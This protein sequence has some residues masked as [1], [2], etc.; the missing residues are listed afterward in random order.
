MT[1][2]QPHSLNSLVLSLADEVLQSIANRENGE[3]NDFADK[4]RT[5]RP[6]S[7]SATPRGTATPRL[8]LG[9]GNTLRFSM[10]G[11]GAAES[12][13]PRR[14]VSSIPY[15]P[16][17][18][19]RVWSYSAKVNQWVRACP[20]LMARYTLGPC[21][22]HATP[23][24]RRDLFDE[25][26]CY[27]VGSHYGIQWNE[28]ATGLHPNVRTLKFSDV[29]IVETPGGSL[30]AAY[31]IR[32]AMPMATGGM[33]REGKSSFAHRAVTLSNTIHAFLHFTYLRSRGRFVVALQ[34]VDPLTYVVSR[35]CIFPK[36]EGD[37]FA[38]REGT[39]GPKRCKE[40]VEQHICDVSCQA[41]RLEPILYL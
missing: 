3:K 41:L 24:Q 15:S 34:S 37:V 2:P 40:L 5:P 4:T 10:G 38:A 39:Q 30:R 1:L 19:H 22:P 12:S 27:T 29:V 25:V 20:S 31:S 18:L 17:E 35:L 14:K 16:P 33:D 6:P 13:S 8:S 26:A 32:D 9:P 21:T 28:R 36:Y 7:S 23:Q 11:V